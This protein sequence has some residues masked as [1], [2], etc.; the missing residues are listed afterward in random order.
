MCVDFDFDNISWKFTCPA[1]DGNRRPTTPSSL[2][3]FLRSLFGA[4][5]VNDRERH[6]EGLTVALSHR[7]H[8]VYTDARLQAR[9]VLA[10]RRPQIVSV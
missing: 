4:R 9:P 8:V 5:L 10:R 2:L 1:C 7:T 3:D 6:N